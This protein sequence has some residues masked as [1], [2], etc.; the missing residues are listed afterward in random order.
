[1][2]RPV[3]TALGLLV[4]IVVVGAAARADTAVAPAAEHR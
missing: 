2:K 3:A 1:M 4:A